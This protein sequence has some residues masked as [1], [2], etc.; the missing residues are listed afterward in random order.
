MR[1]G[2]VR[3]A[4][5]VAILAVLGVAAIAWFAVL[6]PRLATANELQE[7]AEA[8]QTANLALRNQYNQALDQAE[9]APAAAAEAQVLFAKMPQ[10]AELP[11]LLDQITNAA[12][13]A[14]IDPTAVTTL[15]T[16]IPVPVTAQAGAAADAPKGVNIAT[17]DI[18]VTAE[19]TREQVLDFLDNLQGLD[20]SLLVTGTTDTAVSP[21][22]GQAGA[23]DLESMQVVG[24]M[25]VLESKLPDLVATVEGLIADATS[26]R[27]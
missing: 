17:M 18:G 25:F 6:S 7:Q 15:T 4:Q 19:G 9:A 13:A 2:K 27:G 11:A 20:R 26:Q 12:T 8:L 3:L 16:A 14:G 21:E 5:V 22:P 24:E 23:T 10:T 1:I